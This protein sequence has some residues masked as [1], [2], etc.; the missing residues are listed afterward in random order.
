LAQALEL[1]G[2]APNVVDAARAL[3][4]T[5]VVYFGVSPL[6]VD[7]LGSASG[8]E[9]DDIYARAVLTSLDDVPVRVI[10]IDDLI[11]NK[12]A[13]GRAQDLADLDELER[14]RSKGG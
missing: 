12:R 5:E 3:S 13:S 4:P 9:F 7:I 10:S 11:V 8:I 6:R 1:F 14:I 2:A